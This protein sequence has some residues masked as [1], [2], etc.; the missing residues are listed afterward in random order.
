M[1]ST[2]FKPN[3]SAVKTAVALL[4]ASL[5]FVHG[6]ETPRPAFPSGIRLATTTRG[7]AAINALGKK[8][9]E[10]AAHYRKTPDQLRQLLRS[11]HCL[12]ADPEGRLF[13]ACDL[14][15]H[16]AAPGI[17]EAPSA[18]IG[19][20]DP[21]PFPTA[22]AFLLHSRPG[23]NR[24]IYLDF[25]G[26]I[27]NTPGNWK[28]GASAPPFDT[29]GDTAVFS[30]SERE[31]IIYIWQRVAE[32][33]AIFDID[34]TT[35][36]PGV[37][38]LRKSNGSD[39]IY[40]IRCVIG[41]SS[42]GT[43]DWYVNSAGGVAFVGTFDA[44]NDVPCWV[45][46][47]NLGNS[48][49]N[50]AEAASHE[51][52]HTLGLNHDGTS[53]LN[54]YSGHGNWAPIMG[55]GYSK[56]IVQWS[57]GEYTGANNLQDDLA[58][59]LTQGAVYRP[60]DHGSTSATATV[61]TADVIPILSEGV[62]EKRADLD[63]F[64]VTA[65]GGSLS[66][67][68]KLAP[69]SSNLRLEVKLYDTAG[70][71]LQ[72]ASVT[73]SAA[74][75]TLPVTLTR[76][77][78]AGD[79]F[80]SID[81]IGSGDPLSTGYSDYA[82]LGQYLLSIT[83]VQPDGTTWLPTAAGTYEW[84]T[85][86]NW[87]VSPIIN[88]AGAALR[89]NN[90][91]AGNQTINLA[92]AVSIGSLFLG[93]SNS[94]HSFTL[95]S[96]G[97]SL[98]FDNLTAAANLSKTSGSND[99]IS[100]PL[101][102]TSNLVVNQT[103]A[104]NLSLTG[105]VTGAGSL[106][107]TGAGV[108]IVANAKTYTGTT[109][110]DDGVLRIDTSDALP[111][112]NLIIG[113]GGIV[114]LAS[115]FSG[116]TQGSGANQVQWTGSGGFAAFGANRSVGLG[117]MSWG[118][119]SLNGK[120][121]VLGHPTA[122]ATLI[123]ASNISLAGGSRTVQVDDGTAA[124]DARIS[125]VISAGGTFNKTG[126][127]TLE[128]TGNNSYT[129]ITNLADGLLLLSHASA[130]P[131]SNLI[132]AGG[133]LGLG[134]GNFT[135]RTLGTS[136]SQVRWT[137][138]SGFAAFG[139][140]RAVKFSASS[141]NWTD[142]HFIGDGK[143]LILSHPTANAT[144]DW[145]Q[146]ISLINGSR[147]IEVHD[148]SAD[149]DAQISALISGGS[150]SNSPLNKTGEGTLSVTEQNTHFGDTNVNAGTLMIGNGGTTGGVSQ[151][152][153][154]ITV[155][156]GS[157]LAMN[158]SDIVSQ[159]SNTLKVAITGEGG[160]SQTGSGTTALTLA[161]PYSGDTTVSAGTLR[162]G[163]AAAIG[164][165]T[166]TLSGGNLDSTV[167]NLVNS[168]NNDQSWESDFTFIGTQNLNL[169]TG[170][171]TLNANRTVTVSANTLTVGG[172]IGGGA[173]GLTKQGTGNLILNGTNTFTGPTTLNASSG[174]LEIGGSG[175][176]GNGSY[177]ADIS[178][179]SGSILKY[180]S[181]AAQTLSGSI[182]GSGAILKDTGTAALTLGGSS[183]SFTGPITLN[184]GILSLTNTAALGSTS[185]ITLAGNTTLVTALNGISITAPITL[186]SSGSNS[187]ISFGIPTA[188]QASFTL[189]GA[190]SGAGN[191]IFTTPNNS[192]G[193]N[194]QSIFLGSANTYAGAT[195]ITA[196]ATGNTMSVRA[197]VTNALPTTTV[198]TLDGGNGSGSGRTTSYDLNGFHQTLAGLTNVTELSLR[199]QRILNT[200]G[201]PVTLTIQDNSDR[202]FSGT[203]NGTNLSLTK[204]G[205][206]K[207][208]LTGANAYTGNTTVTAGTLSLGTSNSSNESSTV[209][210]AAGALLELNFS[211]SDTVDKLFIGTTQKPAGTYGAI[212][213]VPPVIGI[214][215][216][217]GTGTLT[218]ITGSGYTTWQ[219]ANNTA[220]AANLDHDNDGVSNAVEHFLGGSTNTTGFTALPGVNTVGGLSVTWTKHP[221]Y[222]G[223]Y[224]TGFTV[225]TSATLA[226]PWTTEPS[227]GATITF[228]T[229]NEVKFT[230]PTPLG[231]KNFTRLKVTGP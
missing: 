40:G 133:I 117:T 1:T 207:F 81:G 194:L 9:P 156:S 6:Q 95:A 93:D 173:F 226:G 190:I 229:A 161:N 211:G 108:L 170:P 29:N 196:G 126:G 192:S 186:G 182:S 84:N 141:L 145:Q 137:G 97:G 65:A 47:G 201:T 3:R 17:E 12:H 18:I 66:I 206:G 148:G 39:Q 109:T 123:W 125:G 102:F 74:T 136:T 24:V 55:V 227:P 188:A 157:T 72:T 154:N 178:I 68:A 197:G 50:I 88:A 79:Y 86:T 101:V 127:G 100:A 208:T 58:V 87:S 168:T 26:H 212:G 218:V 119:V 165:G 14:H 28:E 45:F 153:L 91:I 177:A 147:T 135:D 96:T 7:E 52:G 78:A 162:L 60:D 139:A 220:Q 44:S 89:V 158:R 23:A 222:T 36:D 43:G 118:S 98:T 116:R 71:L 152:S 124:I 103:A 169:G 219:S 53:S 30:T 172:A 110:V 20:T 10:V 15:K 130:L 198:L 181:T 41:G 128:L 38:A 163:N 216:I 175:R 143:N 5:V 231:S 205:T 73:D 64:R 195:T 209:T 164:T 185:A 22:E 149:I 187:T 69:R 159:G 46:P 114:G 62:I 90:N 75:G 134:N 49:K 166:L 111:S 180:S 151:N 37:E 142:T 42:G 85:L 202:A 138:E 191:L 193:N 132:L 224:T 8:L 200:S 21:A 63:F 228:P 59:M 51:V 204:A 214:P 225:E 150:A 230:F 129:A 19:P 174:T 35:E 48:E 2:L 184:A 82:S 215:Q 94:T 122:D 176:L 77:V 106:T 210:I 4:A 183:T 146:A 203:I 56:D 113:S 13:Y 99:I 140:T 223:S 16:A 34:V 67:N 70:T 115:T 83:G 76:T 167:A 27:D 217:T 155:A 80:F 160:F 107:K 221:S 112:G 11:D 25:D 104:G 179:G 121:L 189:N 144:L 54:Y 92:T 32:D 57:K 171:V 31:R 61:L 120:I 199:N 131:G 105:P 213:S 33:F